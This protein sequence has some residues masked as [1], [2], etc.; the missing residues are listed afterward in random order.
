MV[1]FLGSLELKPVDNTRLAKELE[2]STDQVEELASASAGIRKLR[3]GR[4]IAITRWEEARER[5][6]DELTGF[7]HDHPIRWGRG[8]GELKSSFGR[9]FDSILFDEALAALL[10]EEIIEARSVSFPIL[11]NANASPRIIVSS[12][13]PLNASEKIVTRRLNSDRPIFRIA[14]KVNASKKR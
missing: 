8:K 12:A 6:R 5:I 7:V 3:D 1:A 2:I 10:D 11:R 14:S 9:K 4:W 13:S